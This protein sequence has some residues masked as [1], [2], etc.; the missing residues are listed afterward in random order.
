MRQPAHDRAGA[1][2]LLQRA[3]ALF[4]ECGTGDEPARVRALLA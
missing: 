1:R 4:E 2:Q 3:L